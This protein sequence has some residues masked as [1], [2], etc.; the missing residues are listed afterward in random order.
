MTKRTTVTT[1]SATDTERILAAVASETKPYT[2]A[3]ARYP[4]AEK[5]QDA[6]LNGAAV[7]RRSR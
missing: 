7:R 1:F 3:G 4:L 6:Q 5:A 2:H